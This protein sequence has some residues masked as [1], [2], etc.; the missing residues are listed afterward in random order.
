MWLFSLFF[1]P[2]T[3]V[4]WKYAHFIVWE[5][6]AKESMCKTNLYKESAQEELSV[7]HSFL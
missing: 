5:K 7:E 6:N 1:A 2:D 3:L 4:S